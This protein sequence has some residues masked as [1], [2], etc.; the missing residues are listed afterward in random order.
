MVRA[1]YSISM[2]DNPEQDI[3]SRICCQR[4]IQAPG[5]DPALV[6][7]CACAIDEEFDEE[8]KERDEKQKA[9]GR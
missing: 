7:A 9:R 1:Q 6:I 2:E 8:H 5:M 3:I 4:P